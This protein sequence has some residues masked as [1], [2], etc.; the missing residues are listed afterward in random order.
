MINGSYLVTFVCYLADELSKGYFEFNGLCFFLSIIFNNNHGLLVKHYCLLHTLFRLSSEFAIHSK[1]PL[2]KWK[3]SK[4]H[5]RK[6]KAFIQQSLFHFNNKFINPRW[7]KKSLFRSQGTFDGTKIANFMHIMHQH[8]EQLHGHLDKSEEQ[9]R[10]V[11]YW[12]LA[13][14]VCAITFELKTMSSK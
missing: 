11:K 7:E 3:Y 1:F 9:R 8:N 5:L 10:N 13:Q 2:I 12:A 4:V 6:L 14:F